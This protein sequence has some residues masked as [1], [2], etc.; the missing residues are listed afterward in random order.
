MTMPGVVWIIGASSGIG[1]A[2]A[3]AY[4]GRGVMV[5]ISARRADALQAVVAKGGGRIRAFPLDVTDRVATGETVAAIEAAL[6]PID[7]AILNAGSHEPV[8]VAA[9]DPGAF[10]RLFTLN[11]GGA[12]NA[13]AALI[14][15]F[16]GRGAGKIA[17]VSSVAGFGG[18]PTASA[19]GATKAALINM[20]EAL[21]TDLKPHGVAVAVINPGFVRT[22]L[23]DRNEFPMPAI[24]EAGDAAE[25]IVTGLAAGRFEV[26]FPRRLSWFLKLLRL[27]PYGLYFRMVSLGTGK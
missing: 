22:P 23:T 7:L 20:A 16:I 11:V 19:Y 9:F 21:R 12:V 6:G 26:T 10:D 25:R 2:T 13:L 27:L 17:I 18:L 1:E 3:L 5:A 24:I 4:A 14:P 15:R 8:D